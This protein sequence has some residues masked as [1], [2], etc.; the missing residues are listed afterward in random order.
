MSDSIKKKYSAQEEQ[1][2][3]AFTFNRNPFKEWTYAFLHLYVFL[4]SKQD[5]YY[6]LVE[7]QF[8]NQNYIRCPKKDCRR[9]MDLTQ[10]ASRPEKLIWTCNKGYRKPGKVLEK[11]VCR[12]KKSVRTNTWF[13]NSKL[14][15]QEIMIITYNWWHQVIKVP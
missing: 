7:S 9:P 13:S 4:M 6:L 11:T 2:R 15:P 3:S 5:F 14:S 8:I 12:T 1:A 10:D